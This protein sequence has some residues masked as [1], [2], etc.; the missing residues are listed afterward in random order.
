MLRRVT[1]YTLSSQDLLNLITM[2]EYMLENVVCPVTIGFA[3]ALGVTLQFTSSKIS[4]TTMKP[5]ISASK[6]GS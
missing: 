1:M 4:D 5:S 2:L 6:E 3:V